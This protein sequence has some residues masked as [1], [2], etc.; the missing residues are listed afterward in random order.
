MHRRSSSCISAHRH[1]VALSM[2]RNIH[3]YDRYRVRNLFQQ[4][5]LTG[6]WYNREKTR[7]HAHA[8]RS[9]TESIKS[10]NRRGRTLPYRQVAY[11]R[12]PPQDLHRIRIRSGKQIAA[13]CST[14]TNGWPLLFLPRFGKGGTR[15]QSK[16]ARL[17]SSPV[18]QIEEESQD[19]VWQYLFESLNRQQ[20]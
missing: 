6:R 11:C 7:V 13:L 2:Q 5:L 16:L 4:T 9:R 20:E 18:S 17:S 19:V 10:G 15:G 8:R 14:K 1:N 12:D 3:V